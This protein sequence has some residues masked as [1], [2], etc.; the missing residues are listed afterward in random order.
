MDELGFTQSQ[1]DP[2][3][4][5]ERMR[6]QRFDH[7]I[8]QDKIWSQ[9]AP[10][11]KLVEEDK[12]FSLIFW[13]PPGTGK[14]SLAQLIGKES[15][16]TLIWLSAVN[17]GVKDIRDA[18]VQSI[19]GKK[20][21]EKTAIIFLD[22]IHRLSKNQQDVLL[23][24]IEKAEIKLIGATTENPSF[25]VNNAILSRSLVFRFE[26]ISEESMIKLLEKTLTR[27][28]KDLENK[29]PSDCFM[30]IARAAGGDAR[31]ALNFLESLLAIYKPGENFEQ[32]NL[33]ELLSAMS[34]PFDKKGELHYDTISALIKS[35][36]GSH[37]D[38]ALHY[39]A[40]ALEGGE[41]AEFIARRLIISASE[42]IGNANPH[43]LV[44]ASSA[45][46]ALHMIGMPEGRIILA[47]VVTLL[48]SSPKSNR[49]YA[50]IEEALADVRNFPELE[51][52][53]QLRNAPTSLMKESGYGK[54]YAYAHTDPIGAR[55]MEYLPKKL[56]GKIYYSPSD[57]G[58]EKNIQ[59]S[60]DNQRPI[61]S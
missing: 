58:Y 19:D 4:L 47:Q 5:A 50:G 17:C 2:L 20:I 8:G 35:I 60:L 57:A 46:S 42:D 41:D 43:A 38:A 14:T 56:R 33:N 37:P 23:P 28:R 13:G 61:K 25:T 15:A 54:G 10:L 9:S 34:L 48:A 31:R 3:P 30:A 18:I 11:R 6:P 44:W 36:R 40:R 45:A 52:P 55:K 59:V 49:A 32:Q 1:N 24:S 22:E 12:F 29:I 39:L 7:L 16:R 26:K 51:I 27:E 53:M 21:G